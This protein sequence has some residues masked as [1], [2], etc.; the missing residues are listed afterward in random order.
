MKVLFDTSI[1][2]AAM[3]E[4]HKYHAKAIDWLT[5][6]KE[7]EISGAVGAHTLAELYA[8]LTTL[9]IFPRISPVIALRLIEHNVFPFFE[10]IELTKEDYQSLIK[11]LAEQNV[12]GG[13][14]YDALIAEAASKAKA[15]MLI[16]L[17]PA[18][19]QQVYPS[20]KDII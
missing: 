13:A 8:V 17:N 20:L 12:R 1:L 18:H 10:V 4:T 19:F 16:T 2:V 6:V 5:R 11:R 7:K 14:L 9:P 3:V 15:D